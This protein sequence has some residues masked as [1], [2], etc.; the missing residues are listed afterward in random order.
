MARYINK[1]YPSFKINGDVYLP[2]ET[3]VFDI[4]EDYNETLA[5]YGFARL[6]DSPKTSSDHADYAILQAE[7]ARLEWERLDDIAKKAIEFR[8][9]INNKAVTTTNDTGDGSNADTDTNDTGDGSN[10]DTQQDGT[11]KLKIK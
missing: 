9:A 11:K 6:E 2:D 8:D 1:K 4:P 7:K 3:G 10:A 5:H